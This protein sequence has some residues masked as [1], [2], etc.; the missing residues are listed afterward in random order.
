VAA[1]RLSTILDAD[2][3]IV[4]DQGEVVGIGRH[5]EL[6]VHCP[7]YREL[8]RSQAAGGSQPPEHTVVTSRRPPPPPIRLPAQKPLRTSG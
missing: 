2:R 6:F 8:V 3:I 5:N 1:H 7:T 4:L